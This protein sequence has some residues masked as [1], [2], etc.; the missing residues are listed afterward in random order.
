MYKVPLDGN[1]AVVFLHS[2][3]LKRKGFLRIK[4]NV[5]IRVT[6]M[7]REPVSSREELF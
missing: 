1:I 2:V 7:A 3:V 4:D 5:Y 6:F